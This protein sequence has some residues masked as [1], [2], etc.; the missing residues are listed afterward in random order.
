MLGVFDIEVRLHRLAWLGVAAVFAVFLGYLL[1]T[2]AYSV[3]LVILGLGWLLLL[4]YH[5]QISV[6]LAV[7]AFSSALIVPYFPGRLYFW[8][9]A[10]MLGW[11]GLLVT[12]SM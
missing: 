7:A 6:F 5:T 1:A 11:S 12:V 10:A 3:V 9:L 4:P 8:E 2:N